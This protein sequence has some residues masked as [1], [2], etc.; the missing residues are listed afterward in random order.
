MRVA[1]WL[2]VCSDLDE[3]S[4][5]ETLSRTGLNST[6]PT[7]YAVR[8]VLDQELQ[9]VLAAREQASRQA[10]FTAGDNVGQASAAATRARAPSN[11]KENKAND[12]AAKPAVKLKRDF[13]GRLVE[14]T[15][16]L[17]ERDRNEGRRG[18]VRVWVKY[19]EGFNNAVRRP[20]T[21]KDFMK[22]L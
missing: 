14:E 11:D 1:T 8:Q 5:F 22:I 2:T 18:K 10:R 19:N 16:P 3:L 7:R 17:R 20:I 12:A 9:K 13:F 21:L 6:A 4:D 15:V